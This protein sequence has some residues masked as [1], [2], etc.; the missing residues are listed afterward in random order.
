MVST[1][2]SMS[3]LP[4]TGKYGRGNRQSSGMNQSFSLKTFQAQMRPPPNRS[5]S[6]SKYESEQGD[7]PSEMPE[8]EQ[9][10][11]NSQIN[12]S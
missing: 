1:D 3:V 10:Q 5:Q 2:V 8:I 7:L 12:P 4:S 11:T 6:R 9:E